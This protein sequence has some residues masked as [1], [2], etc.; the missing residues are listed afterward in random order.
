[1][2]ANSHVKEKA[3]LEYFNCIKT[4]KFYNERTYLK[5]YLEETIKDR[6]KYKWYVGMNK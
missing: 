6:N 5:L 1:M 3:K 2:P 4:Q